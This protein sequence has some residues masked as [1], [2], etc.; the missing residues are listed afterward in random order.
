MIFK[1]NKDPGQPDPKDIDINLSNMLTNEGVVE[2]IYV[3]KPKATQRFVLSDIDKDAKVV[4][5][6]SL[7]NICGIMYRNPCPALTS[8]DLKKNLHLTKEQFLL[9]KTQQGQLK[10][11]NWLRK[12]KNML[13]E[14]L[15]ESLSLNFDSGTSPELWAK[16]KVLKY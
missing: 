15:S 1:F 4:T 13:D 10:T 8:G 11:Y 2:G 12:N 7:Q 3:V 9:L 6:V 16:K 5:P 14:P